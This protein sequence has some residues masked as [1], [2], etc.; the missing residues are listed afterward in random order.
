M[1][2]SIITVGSSITVSVTGANPIGT[3]I[4]ETGQQPEFKEHDSFMDAL[5]YLNDNPDL[6]TGDWK[7]IEVIHID[8]Y[9]D[10]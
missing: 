5:A 7:R 3:L 8:K 10:G 1:A 6:V 4:H 2:S 9:T